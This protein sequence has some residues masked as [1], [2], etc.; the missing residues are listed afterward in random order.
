MQRVTEREGDVKTAAEAAGI[1]KRH[2]G[3]PG[4]PGAT[5]N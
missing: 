2:Q 1:Q 5:R 4:L 3:N